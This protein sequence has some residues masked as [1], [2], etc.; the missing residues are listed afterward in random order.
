MAA[1]D[2]IDESRKQRAQWVANRRG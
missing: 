1:N 2:L